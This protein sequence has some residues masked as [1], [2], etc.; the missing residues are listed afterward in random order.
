[1]NRHSQIAAFILAGGSSS[2]MGR[3]K[4]L[5]ELG[6]QPLIVRTAR[7]LE[8]LV[9]EVTVVGNVERYSILGLRTI[10]DQK[11]GGP[12]GIEKIQTPLVGIA[13]AL[14]ASHSPWNLILACDLPYLTPNWLD[15]LMTCVMNSTAQLV[16]PRTA[17][18]LEPLA[19]VYSKQCAAP[20]IAALERGVRKVSDALNEVQ[21]EI[22]PET[23]WQE[24]D[25][26][27]QVLRNMNFPSDYEEAKAFL[28]KGIIK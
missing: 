6:G 3:E 20:M 2:R 10:E 24:R 5:L 7:L 14:N 25:P 23:E 13:T 8:S 11:F 12:Q 27:G 21:V 19:A 1:M 16:M 15:W 4:G 9:G 28:E 17:R 22:L 26:N 18:G